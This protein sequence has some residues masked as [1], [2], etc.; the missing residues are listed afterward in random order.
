MDAVTKAEEFHGRVQ[1]IYPKMTLP[2]LRK[3]VQVLRNYKYSKKRSDKILTQK[4]LIIHDEVIK[5]GNSFNSVYRW[6]LLTDS[7]KKIKDKVRSGK[8][9]LNEG[10]RKRSK[11][12]DKNIPCLKNREFIQ[13]I[14]NCVEMY[15][16]DSGEDYPGRLHNE[17]V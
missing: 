12:K 6:L 2:E 15:I 16:S 7:P 14:I 11:I 3:I 13:A 5:Q 10:L 4:E 1:Q 17:R 8:M 9:S